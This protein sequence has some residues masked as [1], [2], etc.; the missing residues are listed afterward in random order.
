MDILYVV[1]TGS[2][3]GNNELRYSLRSIEKNGI[4]VR[5]V[6]IVGYIPRWIN[7]KTVRCMELQDRTKVKH[8]NILNAIIAGATYFE[9]LG[10]EFLYSSD[11]HFYLRPTDFD[12]Y[13]I[14]RKRELISK[15]DPND[16]CPIYHTTLVSTY[17]LLK[18]YKLTTHNFAWHGNTHFRRDILTIDSRFREICK[19]ANTM[20][21]GCEPTCL[22]LNYLLSV[23]P[24]EWVNR[25][26]IKLKHDCTI[27]DVEN[28]AKS[29]EC[30]SSV[31]AIGGSGLHDYLYREFPNKSKYEL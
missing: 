26:D 27:E 5:N 12:N 30:C 11:D 31:P 10:T 19:K 15:L 17:K 18:E 7:R 23:E 29:R 21:E 4:N 2:I 3:W 25:P 8:Y 13:P 16:G 6:Y 24:F 9:D 14:F 20:P 22:M 28:L 1:G